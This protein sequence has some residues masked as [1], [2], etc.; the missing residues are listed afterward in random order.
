M[1][2]ED[3]VGDIVRKARRMGGIEVGDAAA[4]GG[5]GVSELEGFE[6]G[7]VAPAGLD[8]E[9]LARCLG[10]HAGKLRRIAGGWEPAPVD[11][12]AYPGLLAITTHGRGMAVHCYLVWDP[13]T[14][15]AALFDTGFDAEPVFEAIARHQLKLT[16]LCITHT[17]GDHVAALD[18]IRARFPELRLRASGTSIPAAHR[19]R[20]GEVLAV[21]GRT[22]EARATPGHADDGTTYWIADRAGGVPV[23]AVV[24]DALF[25]GSLGGAPD[26]GDLARGKVRDEVLSLPGTVLLCPGH[27]PMTTVGEQRA[28]N[29]F[30]DFGDEDRTSV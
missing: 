4:A 1:R 15:E 13:G 26:K 16:L 2:L 3:H 24:G 6:E 23:L 19:N 18:P 25:A 12:A 21:G 9:G 14:R 30:F 5:I 8:W 29:P 20:P 7:G 28:V 11:G 10:L 22:V 17:H 27:G